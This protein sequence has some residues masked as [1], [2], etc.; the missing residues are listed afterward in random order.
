VIEATTDFQAS[1]HTRLLR[2]LAPDQ[3]GRYR[4]LL[5]MDFWPRGM[6]LGFDEAPEPLYQLYPGGD[7]QRAESDVADRFFPS[8]RRLRN[9]LQELLPGSPG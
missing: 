3:S 2:P 5:L 7:Y 4:L 9:E 6:V 1:T 8:L